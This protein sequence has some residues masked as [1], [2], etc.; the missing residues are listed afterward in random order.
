MSVNCDGCLPACDEDGGVPDEATCGVCYSLMCHPV[1]VSDQCGHRF[2]RSCVFKQ[3]SNVYKQNM[4]LDLVERMSAHT[5]LS[6]P[7][8]RAPFAPGIANALLPSEIPC[9]EEA[10]AEL[11]RRFPQE[12]EAAF[13]RELE[14]E[15]ALKQTIIPKLPL[16]FMPGSCPHT[17]GGAACQLR[18]R[19]KSF[20][21]LFFT[22]PADQKTIQRALEAERC[23]ESEALAAHGAV[24]IVF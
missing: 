17:A 5:S 16:V 14:L 11:E 22:D 2:C 4:A 9:D 8:C 3:S 1:S 6:C 23:K 20:M 19:L 10:S 15:V 13:A 12:F 21:T 7:L 24:G 18:P